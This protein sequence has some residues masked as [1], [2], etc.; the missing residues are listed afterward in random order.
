MTVVMRPV[1]AGDIDALY[2]LAEQTGTGLTTL[3]SDRDALAAKIAASEAS[4]AADVHE[5]GE[6]HYLFVLVDRATDAVVGTSGLFAT[7][8]LSKP[9][10][11]YRL[12]HLTQVS[13]DP[14]MQV[15]TRLLQLVNDYA[16]AT[17]I[18]SLFLHRGHR[19]GAN[20]RLLSKG[21]YLMIAACP[22]RFAP[23]IMAE[24]RGWVDADGQSPFWE[25]IGR[26]FFG[27][28]YTDADRISG[29]GNS[30]F[31][32]DLMPKFPIYTNLLPPQAREV[33]GK[34]H[35]GAKAAIRLLEQ[36]GFR[37]AGAVD[38]F[39]AGPCLE[40]PRDQIATVRQATRA[41][42]VGVTEAAGPDYVIAN[43][44]IDRF[45]IAV[46]QLQDGPDIV[47]LPADT[48]AALEL[49]EGDAVIYA[50]LMPAE[51]GR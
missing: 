34:P 46:S 50:P 1:R 13:H 21:R 25:A 49:A 47:A 7:V 2:A 30:Q 31:I 5:P 23:R 43:P 29:M 24:I 40:A 14:P 45:R 44:R 36:E 41:R 6:E 22:D 33:I 27:M 26:Q 20:G 4:F 18:G 37:F 38:I 48:V 39:D 15:D 12:L 42:F 8:G 10:Y 51:R 11:N 3:P 16:G 19:G 32:A 9:F 17:E 28:E 35:D